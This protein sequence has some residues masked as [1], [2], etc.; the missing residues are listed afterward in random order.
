MVRHVFLW[1]VAEGKDP[2][3]ILAILNE[4]PEKI[5]CIRTWALGKHQGAEGDSGDPW[6]YALTCDFDSFDGL[7]TYNNHPFHLQ[8]IDR[9]RSAFSA[10][11]VCDFDMGGK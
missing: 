9:L 1:R 5:D 6:D 2:N 3:E 10:R 8:V 4:L 11:A 7:E